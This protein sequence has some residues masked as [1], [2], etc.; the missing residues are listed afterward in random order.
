MDS[1][2][3]TSLR[4][5]SRHFYEGLVT[6]SKGEKKYVLPFTF[7]DMN[8]VL[9]LASVAGLSYQLREEITERTTDLVLESIVAAY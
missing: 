3:L 7:S 6:A 1:V 5:S 4:E 8:G 9:R 2:L